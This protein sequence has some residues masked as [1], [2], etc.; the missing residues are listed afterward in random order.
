MLFG[1]YSVSL[2]IYGTNERLSEKEKELILK[3]IEELE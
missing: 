3:K 1:G 2:S